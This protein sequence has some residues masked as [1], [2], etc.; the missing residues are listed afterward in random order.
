MDDINLHLESYREPGVVYNFGFNRRMDMTQLLQ[1][2]QQILRY[3]VVAFYSEEGHRITDVVDFPSFGKIYASPTI[4]PI[5][6]ELA[7]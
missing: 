5:G 3:D 7:N 4:N 1:K 6:S 2:A